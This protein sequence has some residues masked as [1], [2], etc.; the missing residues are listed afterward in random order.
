[1]IDTEKA[2]DMLPHAV[3]I[4]EQ[5]DIQAYGKRKAEE[6]KKKNPGK[7]IKEM[8]SEIGIDIIKHIVKSSQKVKQEFFSIVA[9]AAGVDLE[10]AKKRPLAES[11][12]TFKEIFMDKDLLDFFKGAMQ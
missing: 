12:Q 1:M 6:Y 9:I 8:Q 11:M 2:F 4:F 10:T 7:D 3:E 5:L